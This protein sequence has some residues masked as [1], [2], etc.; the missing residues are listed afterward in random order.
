MG[1]LTPRQREILGLWATG[2]TAKQVAGALRI[3]ART[4][5]YHL[6]QVRRLMQMPLVAVAV[7]VAV[8]EATGELE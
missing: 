3:S 6:E 7:Y 5:E 4:V 1:Q 8:A 2:M